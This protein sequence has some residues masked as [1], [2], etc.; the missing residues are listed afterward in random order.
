[1]IDKYINEKNI[2]DNE[3]KSISWQLIFIYPR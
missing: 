2:D 1:M 3:L